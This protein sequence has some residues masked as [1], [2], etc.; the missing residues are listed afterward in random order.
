MF[1]LFGSF[2]DQLLIVLG[3]FL[4]DL[5]AL[6]LYEVG[7]VF[8]DPS[9]VQ[10]VIQFKERL[11]TL[12]LLLW[13]NVENHLFLPPLLILDSFD[14]VTQFFHLGFVSGRDS[15]LV[16]AQNGNFAVGFVV[17]FDLL[18]DRPNRFHLPQEGRHGE[19]S[20]ICT[21]DLGCETFHEVG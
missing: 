11:A 5:G 13:V 19:G 6:L 7:L 18:W 17:I 1:H 16:V 9:L 12:L 20:I 15:T 3:K 4:L 2:G 8:L 10:V 21:E 14:A